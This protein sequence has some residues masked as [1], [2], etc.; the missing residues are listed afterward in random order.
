MSLSTAVFSPSFQAFCI[1]SDSHQWLSSSRHCLSTSFSAAFLNDPCE[2]HHYTT[3]INQS[4]KLIQSLFPSLLNL[5]ARLPTK[6]H[7]EADLPTS[8]L[9]F[10]TSLSIF[11]AC[12]LNS[13]KA[14]GKFG[15]IIALI[16]SV[17]PSSICRQNE[18]IVLEENLVNI[19]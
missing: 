7:H 2:H 9:E 1:I 12:I 14:T 19:L 16:V 17:L 5:Y 15:M 6:S 8:D 3:C 4:E 10:V 11:T 18:F 13:F